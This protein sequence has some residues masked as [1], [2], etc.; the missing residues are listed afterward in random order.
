[1][2]ITT[3]LGAHLSLTLGAEPVTPLEMA[4][5]Y[6]TLAND[7]VR[8]M[9]YFVEKVQ[10]GDGA[11]VFSHQAKPERAIAAEHARTV[12]DVLVQVVNN[13]TGRAAAIP[14]RV[15]GGK[16]GSTDENADA[17]F[18]GFTPQLS[19]AVWM[20]AP[21]GRVSMYN[22]GAYPRVYGGTYPATMFGAYMRA[23]LE[24]QPVLGFPG[25]PPPSRPPNQLPG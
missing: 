22:V 18:V 11:V 3:P 2:G 23:V 10:K 15:V 12:T 13:G 5:A 24:G 20:G 9:P 21:E 19:T 4:T 14:G 25:A 16:T 6:A 8:N 17:W 1:M 7:G